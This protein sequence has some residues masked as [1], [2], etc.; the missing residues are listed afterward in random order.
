[1]EGEEPK[2]LELNEDEKKNILYGAVKEMENL[3]NNIII[4][5][6]SPIKNIIITDNATDIKKSEY[7]LN[8]PMKTVKDNIEKIK[9]FTNFNMTNNE[10]DEELNLL[11]FSIKYKLDILSKYERFFIKL[12]KYIK[13]EINKKYNRGMYKGI[14][15]T[16]L[17]KLITN[18]RNL[19]KNLSNDIELII[20]NNPGNLKDVKKLKKFKFNVLYINYKEMENQANI[21]FYNKN[22]KYINGLFK[23]R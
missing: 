21:I 14:S 15:G 20:Q 19:M 2:L 11:D 1:M 13:D 16:K 17:I 22:K 23:H 3:Y 5:Y 8:I 6:Q 12:T 9:E 7:T 18:Y 10:D 4:S